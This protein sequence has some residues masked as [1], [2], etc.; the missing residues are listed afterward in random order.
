M[1]KV[2]GRNYMNILKINITFEL[3]KKDR[4][5]Q[6]LYSCVYLVR[7]RDRNASKLQN[8]VPFK[9]ILQKRIDSNHPHLSTAV[10]WRK[11]KSKH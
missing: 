5:D 3:K 8:L 9:N 6:R 10:A 2:T 4:R 11:K 1:F 7:V